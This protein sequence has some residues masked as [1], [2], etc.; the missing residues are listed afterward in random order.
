MNN[1]AAIVAQYSA[2]AIAL[3]ALGFTAWQIIVQRQHN[4][5]SVR[6]FL[7]THDERSDKR[8]YNVENK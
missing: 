2:I 6:P 5:I 7:Y 3:G 8:Q 1:I 4:R